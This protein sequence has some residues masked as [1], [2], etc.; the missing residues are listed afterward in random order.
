MSAFC[1]LQTFLQSAIFMHSDT[2][3]KI[4]SEKILSADKLKIV[5][6]HN[7]DKDNPFL[8]IYHLKRLFKK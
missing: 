5:E 6:V 4:L 1:D 2:K 7:T 8:V 3:D